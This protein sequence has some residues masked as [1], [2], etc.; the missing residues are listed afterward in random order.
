M[1]G[2]AVEMPVG[3]FLPRKYFGIRES[4]FALLHFFDL[5]SYASRKNPDAVL[6]MF[7]TIRKTRPYDDIQLVLKVKKADEDAGP[8][9]DTLRARVP[10][11]HFVSRPL[12]ALETR[13]LINACDCFISL[14]R[15]EGFG[16][17]MGEA[18]SLGRLA[19]GTGWSGNVD[20]MTPENSL[21]V[22]Y[23]PVSVGADEYPYGEGQHWAE[24]RVDH[25]AA[26]LNEMLDDPERRRDMAAR[27][28]RDI[29]LG[30]SYRAVGVRVM[31][32]VAEIQTELRRPKVAE[33]AAAE[34]P[35]VT[36]LVP[37]AE[38]VH[39]GD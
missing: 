9:L 3:H 25:A 38:P 14:H 29:R 17:G 22:D 34:E 16:R 39:A 27:G 33:P 15:S 30:Y 32:R 23:D 10:E 11:A 37:D 7:D 8:W 5:S 20:F 36:A 26:L 4:S 18:M 24:A 21:L 6:A 31:N 1:I 28:R 35:D 2:Q 12:S 13:S 19:M